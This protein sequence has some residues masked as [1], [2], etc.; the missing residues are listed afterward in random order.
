MNLATWERGD[1]ATYYGALDGLWPAERVIADLVLTPD[2]DMVDIGIGGGR[3]TKYFAPRCRSYLGF[4]YSQSMVDEAIRTCPPGTR[5]IQAD[6]TN[7]DAIPDHSADFIL[8]SYNGIDYV[9]LEGRRQ[10]L[11]ECRRIIRPGGFFAVSS[12]NLT[13]VPRD[14]APRPGLKG[15]V[16][17]IL[18][19]LINFPLGRKVR[20]N[21]AVLR[22]S[23][24]K[25]GLRTMYV[26][27]TFMAAELVEAGFENPR[28]FDF[29]SGLEA[30]SDKVDCPHPYFVSMAV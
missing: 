30:T 3:T 6:A 7:M 18:A 17:S 29:N 9:P 27:P 2:T 12:H 25:F 11:K 21:Y 14:F 1:V 28:V 8:F 19:R 20:G 10:I 5:I 24:H 4:D 16:E 13:T 15:L 26:R 22:D 23:A